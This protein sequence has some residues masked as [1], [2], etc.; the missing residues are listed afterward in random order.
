M[1]KFV[2]RNIMFS[3]GNDWLRT[4]VNDIV[5]RVKGITCLCQI[6]GDINALVIEEDKS[7]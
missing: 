5:W 4:K 6:I 1:V 2:E 3:H 7:C